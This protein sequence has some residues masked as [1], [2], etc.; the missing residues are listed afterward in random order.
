MLTRAHSAA[1]ATLAGHY[2][3]FFI[4]NSLDAYLPKYDRKTDLLSFLARNAAIGFASSAVSDTVSNSLR[5]LKTTKQS[6]AEAI[7]YPAAFRL[8]VEKDG[9]QGLFLRGL[10][11]KIVANGAQGILF[12]ILWRLGQD[13]WGERLARQAAELSA[14]EAEANDEC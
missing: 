2:P 7:T 8:V 13:A 1:S 14:A 12:S 3:F 6:S 4:Y 10:K 11:T 5:V 9:L